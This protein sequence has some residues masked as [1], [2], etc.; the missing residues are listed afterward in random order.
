ML[1]HI[2]LNEPLFVQV[3]TLFRDHRLFRRLTRDYTLAT[4]P[5]TRTK[6]RAGQPRRAPRRR[7]T[8][9]PTTTQTFVSR[10]ALSGLRPIQPR[11]G[12]PTTH[13]LL[14]LLRGRL[15]LL[16]HLGIIRCTFVATQP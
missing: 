10:D 5:R 6:H 15:G 11:L 12:R 8:A 4:P 1:C 7:T 2:L 16:E 9:S 13:Y 14:L 3:A